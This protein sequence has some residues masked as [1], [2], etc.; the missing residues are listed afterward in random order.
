MSLNGTYVNSELIGPKNRIL[1][2][3]N[4]ISVGKTQQ[5]RFI[6]KTN[7]SPNQE[8][9][10][11]ITTK[12]HIGA[13]LGRGAF[14]TVYS[15]HDPISCEQF[16][17]KYVRKANQEDLR[18]VKAENEAK[19]LLEL[20]HPCIIRT[21]EMIACAGEGIALRLDIM[22]GGDLH[23]RIDNSRYLREDNAKFIFYQICEGIKYLHDKR[24][25]HRDIKAENILLATNEPNPLI[26]ITD[27]GLSKMIHN[28]SVLRTVC[29]TPVFVAPEVLYRASNGYN[30][31]V[32]LWSLGILLLFALSGNLP[33]DDRVNW[34][35]T[36]H[37]RNAVS[38]DVV[39]LMSKLLQYDPN[40]RPSINNVLNDPWFQNS[41]IVEAA[42][43][44]MN[45]SVTAGRNR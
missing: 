28:N 33:K 12:F 24:V 3:D 34:V 42:K 17:L 11:Q 8:L 21:H 30:N 22:F 6:F 1:L 4:V 36:P 7:H 20:D 41:R 19:I 39:A 40:Q 25:T 27:F 26:K 14:G 44:A 5:I 32:D 2:N 45:R 31:K 15:V 29:G 10:K 16:A 18:L 23:T 43:V 37:P 38:N 35:F 13:T 9:P